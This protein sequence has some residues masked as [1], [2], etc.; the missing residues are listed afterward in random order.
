MSGVP[1][2]S[3]L[4]AIPAVVLQHMVRWVP[5]LGPVAVLE[6]L[7]CA[8]SAE[9]LVLHPLSPLGLVVGLQAPPSVA[10]SDHVLLG[11]CWY[12]RGGR[13]CLQHLCM[14]AVAAGRMSPE[15]PDVPAVVFVAYVVAAMKFWHGF[16]APGPGAEEVMHVDD[17]GLLGQFAA[18]WSLVSQLQILALDD[19]EP[20]LA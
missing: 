5:G 14:T 20:W 6:L 9:V 4:E 2:M 19:I 8:L 18:G 13:W 7:G 12:Q 3:L 17:L 16:L 1:R 15:V 10:E 11:V